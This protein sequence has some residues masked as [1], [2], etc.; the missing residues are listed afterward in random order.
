M[1]LIQDEVFDG[2]FLD[3]E[4]NDDLHF[5]ENTFSS[6]EQLKIINFKL[7][8]NRLFPHEDILNFTQTMKCDMG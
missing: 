6:S 1:K 7:C 8:N 2:L 5:L 3:M 4:N